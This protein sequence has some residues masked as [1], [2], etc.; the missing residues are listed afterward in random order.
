MHDCSDVA[1]EAL[2]GIFRRAEED[3]GSNSDGAT[4]SKDCQAHRAQSGDDAL[5][6]NKGC[7]P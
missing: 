4:Q 5:A 1:S 7:R 3:Q 6:S 2:A